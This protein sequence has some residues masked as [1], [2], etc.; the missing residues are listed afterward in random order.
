MDVPIMRTTK[1]RAIPTILRLIDWLNMLWVL[2]AGKESPCSTL[3]GPTHLITTLLAQARPDP[4]APSVEFSNTKQR[5]KNV[6][7][8]TA[9]RKN[10]LHI[11]ALVD[12]AL[13]Q[14]KRQQLI[15]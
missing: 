8:A 1:P 3:F 11:H 2:A 14:G 5:R 13:G 6:K 12:A 10:P 4:I 15:G 7:V 9:G